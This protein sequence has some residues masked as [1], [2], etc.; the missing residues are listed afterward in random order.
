M[1]AAQQLADEE[2]NE[3]ISSK[4]EVPITSQESNERVLE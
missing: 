1:V 3:P 4:V 2:K